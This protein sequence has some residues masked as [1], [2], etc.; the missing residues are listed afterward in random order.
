MGEKA[1]LAGTA[2]MLAEILYAQG[3]HEQAADFC[4][5]SE[6]A[7][8]KED[9]TAQVGWRGVR[10]KLLAEEGRGDEAGELAAE[11]VRLGERTDFLTVHGAAL[12]D[13]GT[14]LRRGGRADEADAAIRAAVELFRRKGDVV[15][16]ERAELALQA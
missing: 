4:R 10:A 9:L 1:L 3:R 2:A 6:D 13:L 8:A 15:S 7:A 12:L 16:A 11:A 14:V 5:A